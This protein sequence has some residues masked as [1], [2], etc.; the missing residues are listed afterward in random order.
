[1][2]AY[3]VGSTMDTLTLWREGHITSTQA[4]RA[5]TN[6]LGEVRSELAPLEAQE[7][8]LR[9]AIDEVIGKEGPQEVAGWKMQI[10]APSR[11]VAYDAKRLDEIVMALVYEYP[12]VAARI[13]EARKETSRAGSLRIER[14]K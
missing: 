3:C 9:L 13:T 1:M 8:A 14:V 4:L 5:F 7:K 6:D 11:G 10:T 12:E 2:V